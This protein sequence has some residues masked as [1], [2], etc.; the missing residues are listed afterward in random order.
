[1]Q[2]KD[3]IHWNYLCEILLEHIL[4]GEIIKAG[5]LKK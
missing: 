5:Y 2:I 4:L 1:M 3:G